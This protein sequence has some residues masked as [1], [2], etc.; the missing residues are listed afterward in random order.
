MRDMLAAVNAVSKNN[1]DILGS[2]KQALDQHK[3]VFVRGCKSFSDT[4]KDYFKNGK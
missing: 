1:E 4:M 2:H 3:K